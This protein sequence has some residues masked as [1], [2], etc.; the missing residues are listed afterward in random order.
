MTAMQRA[1]G[2]VCEL[3]Y[4]ELGAADGDA[5]WMAVEKYGR[6]A[7]EEALDSLVRQLQRAG[8]EHAATEEHAQ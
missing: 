4:W 3:I 1:R 2:L 8:V 5:M 7:M 6:P